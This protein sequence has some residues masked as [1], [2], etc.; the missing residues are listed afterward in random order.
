M[1]EQVS[2]NFDQ[3]RM[4]AQLTALL[5]LLALVLAAVGLYGV[6]AYAVAVRTSEIGIRMAL[7]AKPADIVRGVLSSAFFQVAIGLALGVPVAIGAGRLISSQL[8]E[9]RS[10][11]PAVLAGAVAAL[12]GCAFL[13]SIF[14]AQRAAA[15]DPVEAMRT[16]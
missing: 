1:R 8:Y 5:A 11:D 9:V 4:V 12:A 10:W 16:E 14:P 7:G 3:E 6:T 2:A 13:A 15:I